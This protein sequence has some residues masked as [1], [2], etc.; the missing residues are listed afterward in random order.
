MKRIAILGSTGSIGTQALNVVR[1]H[2]DL[3]DIEVLCAGS[4]ADLLISQA[5]EFSPNAVVVADEGKYQQ[6]R[7]AL[8]ATDVKVFAGDHT[9]SKRLFRL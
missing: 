5:L 2:R 7:Q 8:A 1:R 4:N 9:A 6:V 3:F